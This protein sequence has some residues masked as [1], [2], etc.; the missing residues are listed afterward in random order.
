MARRKCVQHPKPHHIEQVLGRA[1]EFERAGIKEDDSDKVLDSM[2]VA[3]WLRDYA[4]LLENEDERL[5]NE[6][7]AELIKA[8]K[9]KKAKANRAA[10]HQA[11][12][13]RPENKK[14]QNKKRLTR[15][16]NKKRKEQA[17][18]WEKV[19][20]RTPVGPGRWVVM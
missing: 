2:L 1:A 13:A 14:K 4:R 18:R 3:G 6:R 12:R 16:R 9:F 19:R 17:A 10:R 20:V 15:W 8:Q 7:M 11:R 5:Y